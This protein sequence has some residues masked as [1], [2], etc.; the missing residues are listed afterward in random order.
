M[1]V[2]SYEERTIRVTGWQESVHR[3]ASEVFNSEET[4]LSRW[5]CL[6]QHELWW[7]WKSGLCPTNHPILPTAALSTTRHMAIS[8]DNRGVFHCA[9]PSLTLPAQGLFKLCNIFK[10]TMHGC[11]HWSVRPCILSYVTTNLPETQTK[12]A[13][14]SDD[15]ITQTKGLLW[16]KGVV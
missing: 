14:L 4:W 13:G 6:F 15:V 10:Y 11:V 5:L 2:S 1:I 16:G 7:G 8:A 12:C 3:F 9:T